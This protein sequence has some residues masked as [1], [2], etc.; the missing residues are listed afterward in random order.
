MIH[1]K[2]TH[3]KASTKKEMAYSCRNNF[4][5]IELPFTYLPKG[6]NAGFVHTGNTKTLH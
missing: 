4:E 5:W 3:K 6:S 2:L 1:V